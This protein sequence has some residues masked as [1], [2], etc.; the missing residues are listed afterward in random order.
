MRRINTNLFSRMKN[1]EVRKASLGL[2]DVFMVLN[3]SKKY[4]C[5]ALNCANS[6]RL[7]NTNK[8]VEIFIGTIAHEYEGVLL[9]DDLWRDIESDP[10]FKE[11]TI[12]DMRKKEKRK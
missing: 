10:Y 11:K 7:F 8:E 12:I 1:I 9:V 6:I 5:I 3:S 4:G 2:D